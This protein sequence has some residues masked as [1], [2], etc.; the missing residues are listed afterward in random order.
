MNF[1]GVILGRGD[2]GQGWFW[3]GV[4]LGRGDFDRGDFGGVIL[5]GWLCQGWFHPWIGKNR[6]KSLVLNQFLP[7]KECFHKIIMLFISWH[8]KYSKNCKWYFQAVFD[9]ILTDF[10][11]LLLFLMRLTDK[12]QIEN[13][14]QSFFLYKFFFV[15]ISFKFRFFTEFSY[16]VWITFLFPHIN[17]TQSLI[18]AL[19]SK[20]IISRSI[21]FCLKFCKQVVDCYK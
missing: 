19:K 18:K 17:D 9:F 4:I 12:N 20:N 2:Y 8:T 7:S 16:L 13:T 10:L 6:R 11:D 1:L 15:W 21:R 14:S 5:A 3:S